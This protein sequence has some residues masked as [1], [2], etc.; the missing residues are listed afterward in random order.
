MRL[1]GVWSLARAGVGGICL[2][3]VSVPNSSTFPVPP[4]TQRSSG[5]ALC[6][7]TQ[8]CLTLRDHMDCSPPGSVHRISQARIL[9]CVA[10]SF[11]RRSSQPRDQ[12]H[13]FY[14]CR[15]VLYHCPPLEV[16]AC[17]SWR[18]SWTSAWYCPRPRSLETIPQ[19]L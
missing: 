16:R 2:H 14:I 11:S 1:P 17:P 5:H 7:R 9:E 13:I 15:R 19:V 4:L 8:S 10:I 6:V 12:I 18:L 3:P